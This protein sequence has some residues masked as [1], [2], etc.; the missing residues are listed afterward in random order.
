M[1]DPADKRGSNSTGQPADRTKYSAWGIVPPARRQL[2]RRSR[3]DSDSNNPI[4]GLLF[5]ATSGAII[6]YT[7]FYCVLRSR[8]YTNLQWIYDRS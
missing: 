3:V 7:C 8:E 5:I 2:L 6:W 4:L 1:A